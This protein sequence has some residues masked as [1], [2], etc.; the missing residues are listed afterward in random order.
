MILSPD[1][2][3]ES[4]REAQQDR[5][6]VYED[7]L[8]LSSIIVWLGGAI[9]FALCDLDLSFFLLWRFGLAVKYR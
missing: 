7:H 2:L 1:M 6:S 5:V 3:I 9:D 4:E 8:L